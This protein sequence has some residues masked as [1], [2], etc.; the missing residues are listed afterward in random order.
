MAMSKSMRL[1]RGA[2][3]ALAGVLT[4]H[5][6]TYRK[7]KR[8]VWRQGALFEHSVTF[9][10]S[11]GVNSLAGHVHL[12]VRA[13]AWSTALAD[14][15]RR[16]GIELPVNEAVLFSTTIENIFRPA[17]PYVRY[18]VGDPGARADVL[19]RIGGALRTEALRAFDLVETPRALR[20]AID[21]GALP[22]LGEEGVRDY[23]ACF[24]S[25]R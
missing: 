3:D 10:T 23:F 8:E 25:A 6:F 12:E 11:R 13:T 22:C 2:C 15:R 20:A 18:D 17:P 14:H 1:F 5:G 7:S 9:G 24:G 21:S 16:R 4:P 19:A